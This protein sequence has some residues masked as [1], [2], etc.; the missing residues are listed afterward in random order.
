MSAKMAG[1]PGFITS[2]Q[3]QRFVRECLMSDKSLN[4]PPGWDYNPSAWSQRWPLIAIAFIGF[5]IAMYLGLFQLHF[6]SSVW[7]PIFGN[8]SERVLTSKVSTA[9]PVP[10]AIL[11][12]FGYLLDVVTGAIGKKDR[13]RTKP[14]IVI[15][16]GIAVGPLGMTSVL[17]VIFQ[18]VLVGAWCTLCMVTALISVLM[19]SP[20][21]DEMLASLQYLQRVKRQ[22]LSVSE[23]FW[24]KTIL[25]DKLQ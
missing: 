6:I 4:I 21:L 11:G 10:D 14:W 5:E 15:L 2:R 18:P 3:A 22:G 16:F 7:D 25:L 13:W 23:A 9:L 17:L 1:F 24:G 19:I 20:A 8:G 12:A